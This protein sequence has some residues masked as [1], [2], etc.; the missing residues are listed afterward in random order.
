MARY[1]SGVWSVPL[2][3]DGLH[4]ETDRLCLD[5]VKYTMQHAVNDVE[6]EVTPVHIFHEEKWRGLDDFEDVIDEDALSDVEDLGAEMAESLVYDDLPNLMCS[7]AD[8]EGPQVQRDVPISAHEVDMANLSVENIAP[9]V[10]NVSVG[11]ASPPVRSTSG[12]QVQNHPSAPHMA[13]TANASPRA[14]HDDK[15]SLDV[16]ESSACETDQWLLSASASERY[17]IKLDKPDLIAK[18]T[19][20]CKGLNPASPGRAPSA[21]AVPL[22]PMQQRPVGVLLAR[23]RCSKGFSTTHTGSRVGAPGVLPPLPDARIPALEAV[24]PKVPRPVGA[25]RRPG[26]Q[27]ARHVEPL[28]DKPPLPVTSMASSLGAGQSRLPN[29]KQP[30]T[31]WHSSFPIRLAPP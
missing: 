14:L 3:P 28:R 11:P 20:H 22:I 19:L 15:C 4:E 5:F 23:A 21:P 30:Y 6:A 13:I 26:S 18:Q 8:A 27:R 7:E 2:Q 25:A 17:Q 24:P 12:I 9:Q 1:F 31:N 29:F 16:V 10:G